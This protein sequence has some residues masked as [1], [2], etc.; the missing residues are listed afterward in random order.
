MRFG[1]RALPWSS[2]AQPWTVGH[3]NPHHGSPAGVVAIDGWA[4]RR[5]A[6]T[7]AKL[8]G[9]RGEKDER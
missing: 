9:S 7:V 1:T 5:F 4:A 3:Y 8:P 6:L 2:C